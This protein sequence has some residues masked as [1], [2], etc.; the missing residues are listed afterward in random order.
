M[1]NIFSKMSIVLDSGLLNEQ[2]LK[3]IIG[4]TDV[5]NDFRIQYIQGP[6]GIEEVVKVTS[7]DPERIAFCLYPVHFEELV[8]LC[9]AGKALPPKSTFFE[10][11]LRSG[12]IVQGY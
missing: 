8:A 5:R 2:V 1:L 11:R 12:V 10:P 6:L 7:K 9:N 3:D 4:I